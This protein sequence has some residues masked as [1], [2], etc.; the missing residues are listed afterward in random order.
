M[1][2]DIKLKA[3]P[4]ITL[5]LDYMAVGVLLG[6]LYYAGIILKVVD[7]NVVINTITGV[8]AGLGVY[9]ASN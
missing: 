4:N 5:I 1:D 9:K 8:L 3:N 6:A 7:P 2:E